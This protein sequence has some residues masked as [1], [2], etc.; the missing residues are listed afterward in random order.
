MTINMDDLKQSWNSSAKFPLQESFSLYGRMFNKI[1]NSGKFIIQSINQI[2]QSILSK[3]IYLASFGNYNL[4][5]LKNY[6]F[7][8]Q[9]AHPSPKPTGAPPPPPPPPPPPSPPPSNDLSRVKSFNSGSSRTQDLP[10]KPL[11]T[12][13]LEDNDV[14]VRQS[15]TQG[16]SLDEVIVSASEDNHED[17]VIAKESNKTFSQKIME[18]FN[19]VKSKKNGLPESHLLI[20]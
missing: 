9:V 18:S 14:N 12:S 10:I 16:P 3:C 15:V 4:D 5:S 6:L 1:S 2:A 8:N 13:A 17:S 11:T 19:K 7:E 20:K